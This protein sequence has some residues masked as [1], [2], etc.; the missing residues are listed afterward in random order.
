MIETSENCVY[1]F[2]S[3]TEV[4]LTLT[5]FGDIYGNSNWGDDCMS[6]TSLHSCTLNM[7]EDKTVSKQY[8]VV[9]DF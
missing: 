7:D 2:N 8:E 3:N 1:K 5:P 4:I 9:F 6:E